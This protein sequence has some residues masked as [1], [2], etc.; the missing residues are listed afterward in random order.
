MP[1][2]TSQRHDVVVKFMFPLYSSML[3]LLFLFS[4]W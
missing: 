4:D 3:F 2:V 1:I